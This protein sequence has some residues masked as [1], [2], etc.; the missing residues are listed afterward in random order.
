[1][2]RLVH[3]KQKAGIEIPME[4]PPRKIEAVEIAEEIMAAAHRAG[5]QPKASA[6]LSCTFRAGA[7]PP[8]AAW[9][10]F[11]RIF[12]IW[13]L[14]TRYPHCGIRRGSRK[15]N[16][17]AG[18]ACVAKRLRLFLRRAGRK[19]IFRA[20]AHQLLHRSLSRITDRYHRVKGQC[21]KSAIHSPK[22][23]PVCPFQVAIPIACRHKNRRRLDLH[24]KR[25]QISPL[26]PSAI[27]STR[28]PSAPS[29]S[30]VAKPSARK[31][32]RRHATGDELSPGCQDWGRSQG[33]GFGSMPQYEQFMNKSRQALGNR[34]LQR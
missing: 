10:R 26:D 22:K 11:P 20:H 1:M 3:R 6:K 32:W 12:S 16:A 23:N 7:S 4:F 25:C 5:R 21:R 29:S 34:Q 24:L 13:T 27:T 8:T 18:A 9:A 33:F 28:S 19:S 14:E 30:N 17:T 15:T 31:S 2:V